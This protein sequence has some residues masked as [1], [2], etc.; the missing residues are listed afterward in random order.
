MHKSQVAFLR[1]RISQIQKRLVVNC[2]QGNT[3]ANYGTYQSQDPFAVAVIKYSCVVGHISRTIS[4]T[5]SFFLG[6]YS[7]I[8]FCKVTGAMLNYATGFYQKFS[9]VYQFYG[10]Q[11]YIE[12]HLVV[13][14]NCTARPLLTFSCSSFCLL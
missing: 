4:Q 5:V 1:L 2:S 12:R 11:A 6:K 8:C 13:A 14:K 3:E 9:S 7:S 10:H